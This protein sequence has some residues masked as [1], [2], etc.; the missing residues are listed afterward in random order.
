[1]ALYRYT[2]IQKHHS[3]WRSSGGSSC[4]NN[5]NHIV[6][7]LN[8]WLHFAKRK[9]TK[10]D[11]SKIYAIKSILNQQYSSKYYIHIPITQTFFNSIFFFLVHLLFV[12]IF[13][14]FSFRVTYLRYFISSQSMWKI[15]F[16]NW[17]QMNLFNIMWFYWY[18]GCVCVCGIL[19]CHSLKTRTS[20]HGDSL[21]WLYTWNW[22]SY[23]VKFHFVR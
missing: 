16:E 6:Y 14:C 22:Q 9:K 12:F 18:V 2:C 11:K 3:I 5:F 10:I 20:V 17:A 23:M 19:V 15:C 4:A 1:M 7:I 13:F 8:R 21:K